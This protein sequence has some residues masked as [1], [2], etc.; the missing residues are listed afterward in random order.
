M[1]G[2]LG[3]CC[4]PAQGREAARGPRHWPPAAVGHVR[5]VAQVPRVRGADHVAGPV[6]PVLQLPAVAAAA[7]CQAQAFV[8]DRRAKEERGGCG[9]GDDVNAALLQGRL[10]RRHCVPGRPVCVGRHSARPRHWPPAAV[11]HVRTVAKVQRVLRP[12][13]MGR[14]VLPVLRM[15]PVLAPARHPPLAARKA[16]RAK[17]ERGGRGGCGRGRHR[18]GAIPVARRL[19]ALRQCWVQ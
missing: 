2:H 13:H 18:A 9:G 19:I 8:P 7:H 16:R 14:N 17:E 11:G 6:V 12:A 10:H 5:T 4:R 3:A 1:H 15:P